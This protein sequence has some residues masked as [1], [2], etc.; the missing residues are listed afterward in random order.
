MS[1]KGRLTEDMKTAMKAHDKARL[2]VIRMILSEMKYAQAA[3]DI[4]KE[5]SEEEALK[6][7]TTYQ[8]RLVKSLEEFPDEEK[9][10]PIRAEIKVVDEYLPKKAS[11]AETVAAIDQV[12]A[13]TA[14]RTFGPLMKEVLAKL[15]AGADGKLVS[16]LLKARLG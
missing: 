11:E 1:V 2:S 14:D 10:A 9:R 16:Q 5:L 4:K 3:I 15:G 7:V 13:G 8:K 6:V 12:M